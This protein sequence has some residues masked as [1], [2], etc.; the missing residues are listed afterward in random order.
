MLCA[1]RPTTALIRTGMV[2]VGGFKWTRGRLERTWIKVIR[3]DM[4]AYDLI[5]DVALDRVE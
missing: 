5:K 4:R 1:A 2:D 3:K